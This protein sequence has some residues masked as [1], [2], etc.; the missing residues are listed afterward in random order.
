MFHCK[1]KIWDENGYN[2]EVLMI[3]VRAQSEMVSRRCKWLALRIDAAKNS[4]LANMND[5]GNSGNSN[6]VNIN[7]AGNGNDIVGEDRDRNDMK[8]DLLFEANQNR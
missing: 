2:Q 4:V 7:N 5:N 3:Y 1:G 6:R 8:E